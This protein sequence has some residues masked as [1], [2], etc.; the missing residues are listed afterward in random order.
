MCDD[1]DGRCSVCARDDE[2]RELF[3]AEEPSAIDRLAALTDPNG[4]AARRVVQWAKQTK[5]VEKA[6]EFITSLGAGD[7]A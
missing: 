5:M 2:R 3:A 7:D 4:E 1:C 6:L